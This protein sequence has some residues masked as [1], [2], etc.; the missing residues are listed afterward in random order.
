M[1]SRRVL[2]RNAGRNTCPIATLDPAPADDL[3]DSLACLRA[4]RESS[5]EPAAAAHEHPPREASAIAGLA[6]ARTRI[7]ADEPRLLR[8]PVDVVGDVLEALADKDI[9]TALDFDADHSAP[10]G[11]RTN[12]DSSGRPL[13]VTDVRDG[14]L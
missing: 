3:R 6:P 4:S 7:D 9:E 8:G 5:I 2:T 13:G 10:H 14:R 12:A 1:T 11:A